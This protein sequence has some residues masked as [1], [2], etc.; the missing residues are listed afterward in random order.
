MSLRLSFF[1]SCFGIA[2]AAWSQPNYADFSSVAGLN[3]VGIAAQ[4]GNVLRLTPSTAQVYGAAWY[5]TKQNISN[6]FTTR[7]QF[8]ISDT[9]NITDGAGNGLAF[10]IQ[11]D[12][13]SLSAAPIGTWY[14]MGDANVT[15]GCSI[16]FRTSEKEGNY[17][18]IPVNQVSIQT[19]G[20]TA[21][22]DI[23]YPT[24][25]V[26]STTV[27]PFKDGS[28]HTVFI[29][30]VPGTLKV[31]LDDMSNP[32]LNFSI[33]F[34][35]YKGGSILDGTGAAWVGITAGTCG[36]NG[37]MGDCYETHDILNWSSIFVKLKD[38]TTCSNSP[39]RLNVTIGG[40]IQP[41]TYQWSPTTGLDSPNVAKPLAAPTSTTV[42]TL[43]VTDAN[44]TKSSASMTMYVHPKPSVVAGLGFTSCQGVAGTL[45]G[46]TGTGG[47]PPY[48]YAWTPTSGLSNS[49]QL[50]PTA[51]PDTSTMYHLTVTDANGCTGV[52]SVLVIINSWPTLSGGDNT[53]YTICAGDSQLIGGTAT[54]VAPLTYQWTPAAGLSA[55][56]IA[57]PMAKP[58]SNT[59]YTIVVTD[60]KGCQNHGSV[61]FFVKPSPRP[62]IIAT[63]TI[64]C[65]GDTTTLT[66]T[67]TNYTAFLW[68]TGETTKSIRVWKAGKYFVTATGAGGCTG[69][70]PSDSITV[71]PRP[72][73]PV[74]TS[75]G[76]TTF[77]EG[78]VLTLNV[79]GGANIYQ[80]STGVSGPFIKVT[81]S[82]TYF[83]TQIGANG[84]TSVSLPIVVTVNPAPTPTISGPSIVCLN[85]T[86]TYTV[87]DSAKNGYIWTVSNGGSIT[88]GGAPNM[89]NI[90]WPVG[91]TAT[92]H[93][94]DTAFGTG[95][96]GT[97]SMTVTVGST[98]KLKIG[99]T[100][101]TVLCGGDSVTLD[102]GAGYASYNWSNGASSQKITVTQ[103]GSFFVHV[104][105]AGGCTGFSDTINVS[106]RTSLSPAVTG[107]DTVCPNAIIKYFTSKN[108]GRSYVWTVTG[109]TIVSGNSTDSVSV[110]WGGVGAG[111]VSLFVQ[112]GSCS[113][114]ALYPV[115][116]DD[117]VSPTIT[118]NGPT[119]FCTGDSVTLSASP[120]F[121][122][123]LWSDGEST[124]SIV[125]R[126]SG[127]YT[128]TATKWSGCSVGSIPV[129]VTVG[130]GLVPVIS[131]STSFCTGDSTILDAGSGYTSFLWST[132]AST[133]F[134]TVKTPGNYHVSVVRGSC[135]GTSQDV[136]IVELAP[137]VATITA[138]GDTLTSGSA[139]TY[140]WNLNGTPISGAATQSYIALQAGN[141]TVTITDNNGCS[142]TSA[143]TLVSLATMYADVS[144]GATA[145]VNPGGSVDVPIELNSTQ[146]FIAGAANYYVGVMRYNGTMLV[147]KASRGGILGAT[148]AIAG[149]SDREVSFEGYRGT[150]TSGTLQW[151]ICDALLGSD[152]CTKI[153]LANFY[154]S[155]VSVTVTTSAGIFCE[156]GI[157]YSSGGARLI[158]PTGA[159]ALAAGRPN[160]ATT[161]ITFDYDLVETGP[162]RIVISDFLGNDVALVNNTGQAAG[163]YTAE[164]PLSGLTSGCYVCM[165]RTPSQ[166]FRQLFLVRK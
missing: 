23:G 56:N 31:Y 109:G 10:V 104:S 34:T 126:I 62:R 7:F 88:A 112:N 21:A 146:N 136:T 151:I 79:P 86:Q 166:V 129:V 142:G 110:Q 116:V 71:R 105:S 22:N 44:G 70:S 53:T 2:A 111:S 64:L 123:Y 38:D 49:S 165:L 149:S 51:T 160:P 87:N 92:L 120:G 145:R 28:T 55:T 130:N 164:V 11:N 18:T 72:P 54:G 19:N 156:S 150:M 144:I 148:Q 12:N 77:C 42:Y 69:R 63:D 124:A 9:D 47:T 125:V 115:V 80:W 46:Q 157:C 106:I 122:S 32:L 24:Y 17:G 52:D 89:V 163:H 132:G 85:S 138:N 100:G 135:S 37:A 73:V 61:V 119:T 35:I 107:P 5:S 102:A 74:I 90:R 6:G 154:W 27:S 161:S 13:A 15:I 83:V 43:T 81:K 65:A 98:T 127:T 29:S 50:S 143:Q 14:E 20:P 36:S 8:Q 41:L 152:T 117:A 82:G 40:G 94:I 59:T 30:Y 16:E 45:N 91:G 1:L 67:D 58:L 66:S 118:A 39:K 4:S 48:T 60:G 128:V 141:Y 93:V 96:T 3:L 162:T 68:S 153:D 75:A 121:T 133:E 113:G 26:A 78:S 114:T 159:V 140:Q 147:P 97:A 25:T 137:P 57:S 158:N 84:C 108:P 99:V 95:C 103:A 131:G 33:D 134:I 101:D 76:P 139:A 155:D